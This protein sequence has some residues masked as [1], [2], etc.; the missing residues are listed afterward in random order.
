M[1]KEVLRVHSMT[2]KADQNL[3][4]LLSLRIVNR[5]SSPR[6]SGLFGAPKEETPAGLAFRHS[7][8]FFFC[9][10]FGYSSTFLR[11]LCSMPVTALPRSY[12]RSD[13]CPPRSSS[14]LG[15][16]NSSSRRRQV[17][18]VH[19]ARPSMPS[20][21]KHLAHPAIASPLPAQRG[22]LPG[23]YSGLDF[24]LN[25]QARRYARPNRV[26]QPTDC[27]FASGCSPPRL[28][29]RQLPSATGIGHLPEG[30]F[31]P[32]DCACSQAHGFRLSPE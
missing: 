27:M 21:T 24:T 18:L 32:S 6:T 13:S 11:P 20:V 9:P 19:T 5:N 31:H 7:R 10:W 3:C 28:T 4:R 26:R 30:D 17:S 15:G 23:L 14:T 16:M 2:W 8:W 25:P 29:T 22:R 12:G 1:F